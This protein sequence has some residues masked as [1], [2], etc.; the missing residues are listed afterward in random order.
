MMHETYGNHVMSC[1]QVFHWHKQFKESCM[2]SMAVKKSGRTV[3]ISTDVMINTV[4]TLIANDNS[5]KAL[6]LPT[7]LILN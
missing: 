4:R 7:K 6:V 1:R 5:L 2:S 3:L